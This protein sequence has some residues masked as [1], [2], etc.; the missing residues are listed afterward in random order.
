[1]AVARLVQTPVVQEKIEKSGRAGRLGWGQKVV[2]H[3][4]WGA[5]WVTPGAGSREGVLGMLWCFSCPSGP[6]HA[7]Q[8]DTDSML[9]HTCKYIQI[10]TDTYMSI[11]TG[12]RKIPTSVTYLHDTGRFLQIHQIPAYTYS[13]Q[14]YLPPLKIPMNTCIYRE[15]LTY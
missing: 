15:Y 2:G 6:M 8:A 3:M 12:R 10:P 14:I 11:H 4:P 1:M 9:T 13:L 5:E 7:I